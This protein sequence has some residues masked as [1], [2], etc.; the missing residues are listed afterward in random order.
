PKNQAMMA[1]IAPA[2]KKYGNIGVRIEDDYIATASG[3]EWI[4]RAPR[5]IPEIEAV[6]KEKWTGPAPRDAATVEAYRS[7]GLREP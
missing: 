7:T 1:K 4:S 5:E 6:M 3:V 2:V